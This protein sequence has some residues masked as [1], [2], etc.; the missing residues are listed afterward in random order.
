MIYPANF[1][2]DIQEALGDDIPIAVRIFSNIDNHLINSDNRNVD[3]KYLNVILT[4]EVAFPLFDYKYD[5]GFGSMDCHDILIWSEKYIYYIY[6]YDGS[7][8]IHALPRNPE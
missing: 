4:P 5:A 8:D 1:L 6:E 2:S 7:T 3:E